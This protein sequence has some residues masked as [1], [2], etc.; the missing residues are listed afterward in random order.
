[1]KKYKVAFIGAGYMT[2]EHIKAFKDID[3]VDLVGIYSRTFVRSEVL[4]NKYGIYGVYSSIEELYNVTNA[5][6]LIISVPE[7][8]TREV[9]IIAFKYPWTI[10]IEKPVGYNLEEAK[11]IQ[12]KALE[13]NTR[14]YVALNRRHYSSTN[15][16]L[17]AV[18][19]SNGKRIIEVHDQEDALAALNV[20]QPKIVVDNWMFANSI[21]IIDYFT[22]FARGN[23]IGVENII[24]FSKEN[25]IFI[26]SKI[27]YDSGDIGIYK[28]I[29]N[30][31]SPWSVSIVTKNDFFEL[32]P[33]EKA[34]HQKYGER[35]LKNFQIHE[36]DMK[37]KPG[38]RRQAELAV[39]LIKN[40]DNCI[41]NFLP[42]L[43]DAIQTMELTKKI[44]FNE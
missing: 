20:G 16:V 17:T 38:L 7:L 6:L 28:A 5:D 32:K 1:L 13:N 21:H 12:E 8:S 4:A 37:F 43:S 2:E 44:Y 3:E 26:L 25:P 14:V 24:P 35:V 39:L 36:W 30:A 15:E 23:V 34:G 22:L 19:N 42:T 31:P 9:A 10:L 29:W 27:T 18:N 40:K 33:L 11:Y 41:Q